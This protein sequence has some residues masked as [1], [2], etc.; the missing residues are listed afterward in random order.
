M[1]QFHSGNR[2][3]ARVFILFCVVYETCN[4]TPPAA[5]VIEVLDEAGKAGGSAEGQAADVD[6]SKEDDGLAAKTHHQDLL[7]SFQT[8]CEHYCQR[9]LEARYV[10]VV[11]QPTH[12]EIAACVKNTRL[13]Q[14]LTDAAAFM[15]FYDVKNARLCSV[16]EGEGATTRPQIWSMC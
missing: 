1:E 16:F 5:S 11:A 2:V 9:Q 4:V 13:Y 14:N 8:Q 12:G 6:D 10:S 7:A 15:A 3:S